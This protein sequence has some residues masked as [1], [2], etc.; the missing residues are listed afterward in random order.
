[1]DLI[2]VV[3]G[4]M[5]GRI[6]SGDNG[7]GGVPWPLP[8]PG[9][10]PGGTPVPVIPP[11]GGWPNGQG[12]GPS[13]LPIP[14]PFPGWPAPGGAAPGGAAPGGA[15]PSGGNPTGQPQGGI[16]P[17]PAIPGGVPPIPPIP[18]IPAGLPWG[19][20]PTGQPQPQPQPKP[21][22]D[23]PYYTIQSGDTAVAVA[24][25]FNHGAT[26]R[27][28]GKWI[29]KEIQ[30]A[31]PSIDCTG[32]APNPWTVHAD[33]RLP[34]VWDPSGP[35]RP[36]AT[37]GVWTTQGTVSGGYDEDYYDPPAPLNTV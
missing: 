7:G 15:P 4:W 16:P 33:I 3:L 27:E 26:K 32:Q 34:V 25:R 13:G 30:D 12:T 14:Q 21:E 28:N 24:Q 23:V 10:W 11:G 1:M 6:M 36:N 31:N 35:S 5:I 18:G 37:G 8:G 22:P 2:S 20:I 17:I 29:W 19:S 9:S